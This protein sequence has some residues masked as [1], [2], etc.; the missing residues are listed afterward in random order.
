MPCLRATRTRQCQPAERLARRISKAKVV[1]TKSSKHVRSWLW[2]YERRWFFSNDGNSNVPTA[3]KPERKA[4]LCFSETTILAELFPTATALCSSRTHFGALA[5]ELGPSF[6]AAPDAFVSYLGRSDT[7]SCVSCALSNADAT[8]RLVASSTGGWLVPCL[9]CLMLMLV[10]VVA[11]GWLAGWWEL[12]PGNRRSRA[13]AVMRRDP[14][15]KAKCECQ[16]P[17]AYIKATL[18][19]QS[20]QTTVALAAFIA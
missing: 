17:R 11:A 4:P 14:S 19:L 6:L 5:C 10:L 9:G 3:H 16:L 15:K 7:S 8:W 18:Y 12:Q 1:A 13:S 2:V 20:S